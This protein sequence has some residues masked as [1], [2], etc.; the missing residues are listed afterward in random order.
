MRPIASIPADR[1][2]RPA[3]PADQ[4]FQALE[5]Y[6]GAIALRPDSMVAHL[7]RGMTYRQRGELDAGAEG[8]APRRRSS[9]RRRPWPLD[10]LGDTYLAHGA[11][12]SRRRTLRSLPR[13][14]RS[15]AARLVQAGPR[16]LPQR[17][18]RPRRASRCSGPSRSTRSL[19][20]AHLL[21]GLCLRDQGQTRA[22]AHCRSRRPRSWRP[23]LT[24]PREALAGALR[25]HRRHVAR[26][27]PARGARGPR[28]HASGP[29]RRARPRPRRARGDT[30]PRC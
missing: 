27:R 18:S 10:W 3:R 8:P 11:L 17:R 2:R 12:R 15:L 20:E 13:A 7:K 6:S 14:R 22:R 29:L 21:L 16:P 25:R 19:A 1:G 30:K 28:S 23:A 26:H 24:A 5:A 4:P 9:T